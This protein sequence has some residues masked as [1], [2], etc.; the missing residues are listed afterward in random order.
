MDTELAATIEL[1]KR[2]D[3]EIGKLKGEMAKLKEEM[4]KTQEK[5]EG[6]MRA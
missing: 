6:R 3:E 2:K 4:A 5:L 1:M